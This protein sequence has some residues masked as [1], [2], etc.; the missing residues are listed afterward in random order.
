MKFI[1]FKRNLREFIVFNLQDIRKVEADFDLR[2]LSEWQAK[3]YIQKLRRGYYAFGDIDLNEEKL[4]LIANRLYAPSYISLEMA[5]SFYG[6]IPEGVYSLTS[7]TTRKTEHFKTR[8][9]DF[10]YRSVSSKLFFGYRL[11][12][13]G[14]QQYK[15]AEIEKAVLDYLYLH[16]EMSASADLHEWRFNTDEFLSKADPQKFRTY[17]QVFGQKSLVRRAENLLDFNRIQG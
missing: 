7:I 14:N 16:P 10:F 9:A 6:L 1:E 15:I 17:A 11:G 12:K 5:L 4:F 8:V 13:I 2:R 3:G